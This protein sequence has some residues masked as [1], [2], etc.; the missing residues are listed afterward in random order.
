MEIPE[1]RSY[2]VAFHTQVKLSV[3]SEILLYCSHTYEF[4]GIISFHSDQKIYY[5]VYAKRE[6]R[7]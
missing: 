1:I 3:I 5:N 7:N 4:R 6:T 2:E